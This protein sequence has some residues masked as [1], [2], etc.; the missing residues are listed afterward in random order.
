MSIGPTVAPEYQLAILYRY[1]FAGTDYDSEQW[2]LRG[3]MK[4]S[5]RA[6]VEELVSEY[7]AGSTQRC[8]VNPQQP[9]FAVLKLDSRAAGYSL[10]F[11]GLF[12]IGGIGMIGG[13]WKKSKIS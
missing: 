8:W 1:E 9:D 5:Q 11:P 13:A 3:S 10:W 2:S 4:K 12:F 7:A 6:E